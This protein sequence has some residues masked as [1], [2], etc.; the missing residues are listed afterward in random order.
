MTEVDFLSSLEF[1]GVRR[2]IPGKVGTGTMGTQLPD[3]VG[4][5]FFIMKYFRCTDQHKDLYTQHLC[6]Q[7]PVLTNPNNLSGFYFQMWY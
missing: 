2:E 7:Y 5:F 4:H 3:F 1:K 6:T